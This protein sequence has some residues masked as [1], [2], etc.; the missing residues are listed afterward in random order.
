MKYT[1]K[2]H[3]WWIGLCFTAAACITGCQTADSGRYCFTL[4]QL[5]VPARDVDREELLF[6][7][8]ASG[9]YPTG[10]LPLNQR[11]Q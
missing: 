1:M 7:S 6:V 9:T 2:S 10:N 3:T 8:A 11:D 4:P 5:P